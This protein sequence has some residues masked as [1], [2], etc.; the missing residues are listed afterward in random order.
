MDFPDERL[1]IHS[2]ESNLYRQKMN[3]HA[4][5]IKAA[6]SYFAKSTLSIHVFED[7][8]KQKSAKT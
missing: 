8:N 4:S 3:R 7:H 6:S 5:L 1:S 2:I